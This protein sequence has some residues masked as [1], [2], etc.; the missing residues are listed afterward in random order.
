MPVGFPEFV[1]NPENRCPVIL[2]LDTSGSM[3][4]QPIQQLNRGIAAFKEDVL[5]DTQ[6]PLK[7]GSGNCLIRACKK[8]NLHISSH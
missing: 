2:L 6:E 7:F 3:S 5:K 4:G 8:L 1:E